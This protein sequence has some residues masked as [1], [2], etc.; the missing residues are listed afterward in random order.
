[1]MNELFIFLFVFRTLGGGMMTS[2]SKRAFTRL[3]NM[4]TLWVTLR[5]IWKI[6]KVKYKKKNHVFKWT[7]FLFFVFWF[8]CQRMGNS[9]WIPHTPCGRFQ[10]HWTHSER[11]FQVD[12]LIWNFWIKCFLPLHWDKSDLKITQKVDVIENSHFLCD[13]LFCHKSSTVVV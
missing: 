11:E 12:K 2:L 6:K 4:K 10:K 1:M 7:I 9:I 8:F 3:Q 5:Q 13:K